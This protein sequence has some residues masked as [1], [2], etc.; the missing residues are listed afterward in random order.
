MIDLRAAPGKCIGD[1]DATRSA[2]CAG[3]AAIGAPDIAEATG[4]R[5]FDRI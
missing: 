5:R 4:Y 1:D 2:D 3:S